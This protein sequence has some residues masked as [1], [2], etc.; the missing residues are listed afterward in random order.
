MSTPFQTRRPDAR[1]FF[2][3]L[4]EA[5]TRPYYRALGLPSVWTPESWARL[6]VISKAVLRERMADFLPPGGLPADIT[7]EKTNGSTGE[8]LR[9]P[10]TRAELRCKHGQWFR[11]Y[12][13]CGLRPWH[14]QAKLMIG[15]SIP[16]KRWPFQRLGIFRRAYFPVSEPTQA[17]IDWLRATKPGALFAWGSVLTEIG[18][19]LEDLGETLDIP[20]IISS[21]D[22]LQRERVEGR[23]RGRLSDVYGAM[24]TGPL[25]WP[26]ATRGGFHVDP[27]WNFVELL[28]EQGQ[29]AAAGRVVCTVYWR[30]TLPLI[31]YDLG[32]LARWDETPCGCGNPHPRLAGLDGRQP[33]LLCLGNGERFT[34]GVIAASLR[35]LD[36]VR[37]F[38]LVQ[39][40]R[41]RAILRLVVSE[42]YTEATDAEI[43][44]RLRAQ[45]SGA[46]AVEIRRT[47]AVYRPSEEKLSSV[48]TLERLERMQRRGI[49]VSPFFA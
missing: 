29:P 25:G 23:I 30:T 18:M 22:A 4:Q 32:D 46:L 36:G 24:E 27:R 17:K 42:A 28:D 13:R 26:C 31:R 11:G 35:A 44:R 33:D 37:Q 7:H 8:P 39:T 34:T 16:A 1:A 40:A 47:A 14:L 45:F 3:L 21:S 10:S 48:V 2:R 6:P 12:V 41:E 9:V 43:Q 15:S 20:V 5:A 19:K 49:D 38:Q